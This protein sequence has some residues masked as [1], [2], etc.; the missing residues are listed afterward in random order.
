MCVAGRWGRGG[1]S[2]K[3]SDLPKLHNS[4]YECKQRT[5]E[6]FLFVSKKPEGRA[7]RLRT[8]Q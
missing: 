3:D 1:G 7:D 5:G 6:V 8:R 4:F 2:I